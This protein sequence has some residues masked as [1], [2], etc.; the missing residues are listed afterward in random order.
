MLAADSADGYAWRTVATL[1]EPGVET[2][3]W[4]GNMCLT[5]S[6]RRAVVVYAPRHFTNREYLAERGGFT[7][8]VD[9]K[10]SITSSLAC[11]TK[12]WSNRKCEGGCSG[13]ARGLLEESRGSATIPRRELQ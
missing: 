2:D 4:I 9:L 3:Q 10:L 12:S 6:G 7:A 11:S 13:P 5:G 8:V 1:S